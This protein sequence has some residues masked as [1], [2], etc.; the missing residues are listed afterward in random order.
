[1]P[2]GTHDWN[3]FIT[4]GFHPILLL[5]SADLLSL[6]ELRDMVHHYE[7]YEVLNSLSP[8]EDQNTVIVEDITGMKYDPFKM[9]WGLAPKNLEV[10]YIAH[11]SKN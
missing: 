4:P 3:K 2:P 9:R 7:D 8:P 5:N 6:E 1:M 11:I 10:N